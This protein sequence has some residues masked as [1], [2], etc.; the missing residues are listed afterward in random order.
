MPAVL[1]ANA[2]HCA[3]KVDARKIDAMSRTS[4]NGRPRSVGAS[5][6]S[7]PSSPP[8]PHVR[9]R[10]TSP[11]VPA[12]WSPKLTG[13]TADVQLPL[14]SRH[15]DPTPLLR[16]RTPLQR[17]AATSSAPADVFATLPHT[18]LP[19]SSRHGG[20]RGSNVDSSVNGDRIGD[21]GYDINV[22]ASVSNEA[23][24][25]QHPADQTSVCSRTAAVAAAAAKRVTSAAVEPLAA[26]SPL[27]DTS[28][29]GGEGVGS[30]G[31]SSAGSGGGA[32]AEG[33]NAIVEASGPQI[34]SC[35]SSHRPGGALTASTVASCGSASSSGCF[36]TWTSSAAMSATPEGGSAARRCDS[37][38]AIVARGPACAGP[39]AESGSGSRGRQP[40]SV[41]T[42]QISGGGR[43]ATPPRQRARPYT[44]AA[45][46]NPNENEDRRWG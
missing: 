6:Q 40:L 12:P 32:L 36:T 35:K 22:F 23:A 26:A 37:L 42:G 28:V 21:G 25:R 20:S 5:T 7:K 31:K 46:I 44:S 33:G 30:P 13:N 27:S 41:D 18:D 3:R 11:L 34:V 43:P 2:V 19:A 10:P 39:C 4:V 45:G 16:R 29:V 17:M 8:L 1:I 15:G 24:S 38:P 9:Q 14:I